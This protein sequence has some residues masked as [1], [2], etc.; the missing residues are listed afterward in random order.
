MKKII[1]LFLSIGIFNMSGCISEDEVIVDSPSYP[2]DSDGVPIFSDVV[3]EYSAAGLK[4]AS[5]HSLSYHL[6]TRENG[7]AE[8]SV[9]IGDPAVTVPR[10]KVVKLESVR[11]S[12]ARLFES[13]Q[14]TSQEKA[15]P[16]CA[17]P[18]L[19]R[20]IRSDGILVE[21]RDCRGGAEWTRIASLLVSEIRE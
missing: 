3:I 13:M 21:R 15:R 12:V 20:L 9:I 5:G 6:V 8:A 17:Y 11:A 4:W 2:T 18:V 14:K 19:A 10:S 16:G 1:L 7:T